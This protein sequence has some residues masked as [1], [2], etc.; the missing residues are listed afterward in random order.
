MGEG[1]LTGVCV[2]VCVCVCVDMY[3]ITV[4]RVK[5][6]WHAIILTVLFV[7]MYVYVFLFLII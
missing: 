7:E 3:I 1:G 6:L 2:C 4:C 5:M